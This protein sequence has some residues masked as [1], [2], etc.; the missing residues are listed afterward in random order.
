MSN[1]DYLLT[2]FPQLS[3]CIIETNYGNLRYH[4]ILI[5]KCIQT[6]E[7]T[8]ANYTTLYNI[9]LLEN[10]I[11]FGFYIWFLSRNNVEIITKKLSQFSNKTFEISLNFC[12]SVVVYYME[13]NDMNHCFWWYIVRLE[14]YCT[15]FLYNWKNQ[16]Y[17]RFRV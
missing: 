8:K 4:T 10:V 11:L 3:H 6:W 7:T 13:M 5:Y 16:L 15:F 2:S 12:F 17:F 1:C 14:G 9:L